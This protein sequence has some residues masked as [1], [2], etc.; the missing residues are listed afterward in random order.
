LLKSASVFRTKSVG[1]RSVT[2]F[3]HP[4]NHDLLPGRCQNRFRGLGPR[5]LEFFALGQWAAAGM[6]P[7][8]GPGPGPFNSACRSG[9]PPA[10]PYPANR[11][12]RLRL[13]PRP[14]NTLWLEILK[15]R[16][17]SVSFR[18]C[19]G[20]DISRLKKGPFVGVP[21]SSDS[22]SPVRT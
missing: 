16:F 10:E 14:D 15:V 3:F 6:T 20:S 13:H 12:P 7:H 9:C 5:T 21:H 19:S 11:R 22:L 17:C 18:F 8:C 4:N 1:R 2:C